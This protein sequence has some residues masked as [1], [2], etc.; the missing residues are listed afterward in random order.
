MAYKKTLTKL[1]ENP[2]CTSA[3]ERRKHYARGLCLNCWKRQRWEEAREELP[4]HVNPKTG[5]PYTRKYAKTVEYNRLGYTAAERMR[6]SS[7][8]KSFGITLEEYRALPQVCGICGRGQCQTGRNLSVD[9]DH[10]TGRVRELL[11]GNCNHGLGKFNDDPKL[12]AA[13]IEYL[14]RTA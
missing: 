3:G 9:H 10:T 7:L 1:C 6:D 8:R 2:G 13:A 14:R 5:L 11:C 12:L 4:A